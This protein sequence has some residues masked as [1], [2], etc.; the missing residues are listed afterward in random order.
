ME[1]QAKRTLLI[2]GSFLFFLGLLNG[3]M[4]PFFSHV[5]GGLSAHLAAV[6]GGMALLI[7]GLM[8]KYIKLSASKVKYAAWLNIYSMYAAWTALL[9]SAT[10]GVEKSELQKTIIKSF[11]FT[12]GAATTTGVAL[13]L[14]GLFSYWNL[15]LPASRN[16]KN[17]NP[18]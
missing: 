7:F 3:F 2:A 17:D 1:E 11:A 10:W 18:L 13:I 6:Q 8:M 14:I 12:G 16:E 4:I 9:L 15:L 5:R